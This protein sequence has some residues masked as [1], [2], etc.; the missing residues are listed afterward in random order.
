LDAKYAKSPEPGFAWLPAADMKVRCSFGYDASD[1]LV[2]IAKDSFIRSREQALGTDILSG[3]V[4]KEESMYACGIGREVRVHA[5]GTERAIRVHA[6]R[7]GRE[8][9]SDCALVQRI[10]SSMHI[11]TKLLCY[12]ASY[13]IRRQVINHRKRESS[14]SMAL[15]GCCVFG[16]DRGVKPTLTPFCM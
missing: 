15:G 12:A 14:S 2:L 8:M 5:N 10:E 7:M 13:G 9:G 11:E 6:C 1:M 4:G 16:C 3:H